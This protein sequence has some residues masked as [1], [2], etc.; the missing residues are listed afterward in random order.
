MA[1]G[2]LRQLLQE[3]GAATVRLSSAGVYSWDDSPATPEA[4]RALEER[5]IDISSHV[6]RRLTRALVEEADLILAMASDHRDAVQQV[7]PAAADR[8][9]TIKEFVHLVADDPPPAPR[10]GDPDLLLVE[11]VDRANGVRQL[12]NRRPLT[13]EDVADP[14]GL[15]IEAFRAAAWELGELCQRLANAVF[16]PAGAPEGE[17]AAGAPG[18]DTRRGV[19]RR[20]EGLAMNDYAA[21]WEALKATDPEVADAIASE[22]RRERST[23]RLIASENYASPSVLA[24]LASSMNNKYAE[25][26]PGRRYY[27]GCEFVDVTERLAIERAT[28][29]FG[30]EHANVQP[31][32]GAQ[33]NMAVYGAFLTPGDPDQK[34]L[35]L[36]LAHGG[37]LTH[38]SPVNF[39]G[40][41]FSFVGYEVDRDT[42][43]IDMD[44]VR[45]LALEHHPKMILAGF[46]AYPRVIDF[47]AFRQI[48]DEVGAIFMVDAAHFIGLVAGGAYPS[49]VPHADVV[50]FTTHK[51]LRGPRGAM[52]LCRE[53]HAKAI[54]K[55]VFPMMQGGP[56]EHT[57]AAK[58]VCL[59]EA[60]RP[61]FRDYAERTVRTARALASGLADQGLRLVSGGTDSHLA[62]VDLQPLGMTGAEAEAACE[63]VG[64][65][66]N[67]NAIPFD[68][69]PPTKASGIRVGTPGPA[70]IG[71]DEP[72]MKEVARIIGDVLR[73][74]QDQAVKERARQAVGELMSRFPVYPG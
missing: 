26:Y 37:H 1:E 22:L 61:E 53:E 23:L 46:T 18:S 48:A 33:A 30:A 14:L 4:V 60:M 72:E 5:G 7:V 54:D 36:V 63:E 47:A 41:W 39:S 52:I 49:P 15:G 10:F 20:R 13:D 71:M 70:T 55:A 62:L 24:A 16:G 74:P 8:T 50:T 25:G 12:P 45:D 56:L 73:Q 69:L 3:R 2:F 43:L 58:A 67:K 35:G 9:F 44:R 57:I 68:P 66:L 6:A 34:V 28:R 42:E 29:L 59:Q 17:P 64:I 32:A 65:A 38:G 19:A 21:S 31:H 51:T 27:G 11:S 40:K